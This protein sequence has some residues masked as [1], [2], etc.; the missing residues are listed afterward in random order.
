MQKTITS[1]R[2]VG[3]IASSLLLQSCGGPKSSSTGGPDGNAVATSRM[4][5]YLA[6]EASDTS[7]TVVRANLNDGQLFGESFR[8]DCGDFLRACLNNSCRNMADNDSVFNPDYIARFSY[9][10]GSPRRSGLARRAAAALH[11][12]D[13]REPPA[14]HRWRDRRDRVVSDRRAADGG[15]EL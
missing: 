2:I 6:V 9:Q 15:P 5:L 3:L 8:L 1:R 4:Y 12:R 11:D 14:G 10:P 13:T 7:T